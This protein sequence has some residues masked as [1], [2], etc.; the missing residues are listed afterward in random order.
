[1]GRA[2]VGCFTRA[3]CRKYKWPWDREV[4]FLLLSQL[5][6]TRASA[7]S[8]CSPILPSNPRSSQPPTRRGV[9]VAGVCKCASGQGKRGRKN[10]PRRPGKPCTFRRG[11]R[12]SHRHWLEAPLVVAPRFA[13]CRP[14]PALLCLH[15]AHPGGIARC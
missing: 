9:A 13:T 10:K 1:L 11:C 3:D 14:I 4:L 6:S 8:P 2:P 5:S 15:T 12:P 7:H